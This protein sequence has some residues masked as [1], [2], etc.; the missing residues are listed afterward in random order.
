MRKK[1]KGSALSKFEGERDFWQK[2]LEGAREIKSS[3]VAR[4]QNPV[5]LS[6]C[7]LIALANPRMVSS[8]LPPGGL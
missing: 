6:S 4:I 7:Q 3:G 8:R 1:L 2:A 5:I